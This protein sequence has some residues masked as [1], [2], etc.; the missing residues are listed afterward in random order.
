M[1]GKIRKGRGNRM[2]NSERKEFEEE[3]IS[4]RNEKEGKSRR[5]GEKQKRNFPISKIIFSECFTQG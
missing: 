4:I 5:N 2:E 1:K 3:K